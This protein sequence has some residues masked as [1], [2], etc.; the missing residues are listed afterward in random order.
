MNTAEKMFVADLRR[1]LYMSQVFKYSL[2]F[3]KQGELCPSHLKTGINNIQN[4]I[5]R[6]FADMRAKTSKETYEAVM[7][8]LSSEELHDVSLLLDFA[9]SI[10]NVGVVV[11]V[12]NE[13]LQLQHEDSNTH[14][15]QLL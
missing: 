12:L 11:G 10:K 1:V 7:R 14:K 9:A 2:E 13:Q 8:E 15:S 6:L 4:A 3:M 5:N